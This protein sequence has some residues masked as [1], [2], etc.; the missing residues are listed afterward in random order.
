MYLF[1]KVSWTAPFLSDWHSLLLD[2]GSPPEFGPG[3]QQQEGTVVGWE[4]E[5]AVEWVFGN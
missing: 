2:N 4:L 5:Q 1:F 3:G